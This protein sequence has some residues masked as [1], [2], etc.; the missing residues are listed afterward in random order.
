MEGLIERHLF[1]TNLTKDTSTVSKCY[2]YVR[3]QLVAV[4]VDA[5]P[6]QVVDAAVRRVQDVDVAI[7]VWRAEAHHPCK[8]GLITGFFFAKVI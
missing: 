2:T 7:L 8:N 5:L 6:F 3:V 1:K 4:V